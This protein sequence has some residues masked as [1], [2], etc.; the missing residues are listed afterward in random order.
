MRKILL[1]VIS[2]MLCAGSCFAQDYFLT[3]DKNETPLKLD[4]FGQIVEILNI[5]GKAS[6]Y[7][8]VLLDMQNT[9][10]I[11][12][13]APRG[14]KQEIAEEGI[15][16][17]DPKQENVFIDIELMPNK[18]S[19]AVYAGQFK[20]EYTDP[21]DKRSAAFLSQKEIQ[22]NGH[23]VMEVILYSSEDK[24]YIYG[25]YVNYKNKKDIKF[26]MVVTA[27][28]NTKYVNILK[29]AIS[30]LGTIQIKEGAQGA[31][32][33]AETAGQ[34]A[35]NAETSVN[36]TAE[37]AA[38]IVAEE[39]KKQPKVARLPIIIDVSQATKDAKTNKVNFSTV[40]TSYYFEVPSDVKASLKDG[41]IYFNTS[42]RT[43]NVFFMELPG[44]KSKDYYEE[45]VKKFTSGQSLR[46]VSA[47][48][49]K[50][51]V[52]EVR[53]TRKLGL[54]R[55]ANNYFF[56][57]GESFAIS[58][59]SDSKDEKYFDNVAKTIINTIKEEDRHE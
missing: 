39:E 42:I 14:F 48:K 31:A 19:L 32:Q 55:A 44:S 38:K 53:V 7:Q 18:G 50:V 34:V 28:E 36:A 47:Q 37:N 5:Q 21:D 23:A 3:A 9:E 33:P 22:L 20:E 57:E 27:A 17:L 10:A 13:L 29:D 16:L 56:K 35:A 2:L 25:Y 8:P 24:S 6:K 12:L 11:F 4:R 30:S 52:K 58:S 46:Q 15:M 26:T 51:G 1:A 49:A 41:R 40:N 59:M 45:V 54:N 43:K